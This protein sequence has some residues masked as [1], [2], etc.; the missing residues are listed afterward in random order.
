MSVAEALKAAR[1]VGI[2]VGIDGDDLVLKASAAP[3]SAVL[4]LLSRHKAAIV[5]LLRPAKD[6]W[7]AEDWQVFF[8]ERAGIAEFDGDLPRVEA[9]ARAFA[10]CVIE[11]LNRTSVRSP[12]GRCIVCDGGDHVHDPLLQ[13]GI[14]STRH[15]WLHSRCCPEPNAGRKT[16]AVA[17][18]AAMGIGSPTEFPGDFGKNGG[19]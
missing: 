15:A 11:W 8:D 1:G 17:A 12:P 6:G 13:H 16:D 4:V 7:S 18:L 14:E 5:A 10:C 2:E 19:A 3:P 9:E